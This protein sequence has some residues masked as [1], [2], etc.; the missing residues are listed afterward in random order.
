[1]RDDEKHDENDPESD[2]NPA[3]MKN[4]ELLQLQCHG[5]IIMHVR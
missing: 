1:M 2:N 5:T 3:K 4:E